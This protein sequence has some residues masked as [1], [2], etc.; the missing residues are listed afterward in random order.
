MTR[1]L[2]GIPATVNYQ[3]PVNRS[4]AAVSPTASATSAAT[5]HRRSRRSEA[6]SPRDHGRNPDRIIG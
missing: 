1:I 2:G 6:F 5:R 4:A 3:T